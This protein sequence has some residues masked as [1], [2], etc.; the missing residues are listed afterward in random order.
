MLHQFG[1]WPNRAAGG[2]ETNRPKS[3]NLRAVGRRTAAGRINALTQAHNW[4]N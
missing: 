2:A 4:T 1:R 3:I